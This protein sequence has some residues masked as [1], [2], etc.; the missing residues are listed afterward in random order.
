MRNKFIFFLFTWTICCYSLTALCQSNKPVVFAYDANLLIANKSKLAAG[1]K[2]LAPAYNRLIKEAEK[3]LQFGPVSVMEKRNI[4]PSGDKHDYMSLAPYH[5]PDPTTP[6]GLPYIRKDGQTNPEVKEYKDKEYMPQLCDKIFTLSAAYFFS[7]EIKYAEYASKLLK[8][9]FLDAATKM[10]PNLNFSQAIKGTNTGRGA[11]LIDAR[12]FIKLID[13]IGLLPTTNSWSAVDQKGMRSWFS[14]FLN[15]MQTSDNGKEEINAPNNHGVWYD[16]LRLSISLFIN[17]FEKAKNIIA[18]AQNRLDK[19]MDKAGN[20]PKE[21]ERT[22]SFHY[23]VFVMDAFFT[24]AQMAEKAGINF[25]NY[26]S[27]SGNSLKKGFDQLLPY[28]AKEKKW[29]GP[30][31]KEFDFEEGLQL[32][33]Y[34]KLKF[35]CKNCRDVI[36]NIAAEKTQ[37]LLFNLLY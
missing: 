30:Q 6:D 13:A 19:Q 15:W 2:A 17:D 16:A 1:D 8:V 9:W 21:M 12:H 36:R 31:I 29:E 35:D 34:G 26:T 33:E 25:W 7:G 20:F 23:T 24:I 28:L 18:N 32:L 37:A 11:G 5:W 14:S 22:T 3:A 4:P 27:P 10:N